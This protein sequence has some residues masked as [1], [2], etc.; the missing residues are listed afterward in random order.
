MVVLNGGLLRYTPA[1]AKWWML[2]IESGLLVSC[3][4]IL[5]TL[6]FRLTDDD[7]TEAGS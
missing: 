5:A 1:T 4:A 6:V 3:A 2:L 7:R